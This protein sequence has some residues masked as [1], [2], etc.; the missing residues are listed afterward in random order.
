MK[1]IHIG[2]IGTGF[3]SRS[4]ALSF[5]TA[6]RIMNLL[7]DLGLGV[8][9]AAIS[10]HSKTRAEEFA[11]RYKVDTA[12][13]DWRQL[14]TDKNID[15][16]LIGS[17]DHLHFSQ[18]AL[19]IENGKHILC[20]KPIAMNTE[21]CEKLY[22]MALEHN[23]VH[24][25]GF[26]YMANPAMFLMK[27]LIK[28]DKLGEI[29]SFSAHYNE[30]YFSDPDT[31]YSWRCD[32]QR[33]YCGAGADLGY[34]LAAALIYLFDQPAKVAALRQTKVKQRKDPNG[35]LRD[36]TTD[37][38]TNAIIKY[39]NGLSGTFQSSRAATGRKLYQRL[40]IHGS[41]G[42]VL[43]DMEDMNQLYIHLPRGNKAIEGYTR[44][45]IGPEH[46][47]YKYFCPAPG[48][49]LSF[50]DFITI[51]AARFLEATCNKDVKPIA[52]LKFGLQ[53][54]KLIAAMVVSADSSLW[55]T[56]S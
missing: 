8:K 5:A 50:N 6:P 40:E 31:P 43:L 27:E 23:I 4:F 19:A 30:D 11:Y 15:A 37:D 42:A 12:Y 32:A 29:Y 54:Q 51:Q 34:H 35:N 56:V 16:V 18:A 14:V 47:Y 45:L 22:K 2:I 10:S 20:E 33:A 24:A 1:T 41:S 46:E 44:V 26:T 53:V 3:I 49:G 25:V 7:G 52:D 36:V 9:L 17:E 13:E 28:N 48:H 38:I 55:E 39:D 21:E